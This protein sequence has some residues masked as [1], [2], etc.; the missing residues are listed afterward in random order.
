MISKDR[1]GPGYS[2]A[3]GQDWRKIDGFDLFS[4][5]KNSV[6]DPEGPLPDPAPDLRKK[7]GACVC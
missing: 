5:H 3:T 6:W 4:V 7:T 2:S 1:H